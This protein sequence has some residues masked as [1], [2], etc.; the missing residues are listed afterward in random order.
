MKLRMYTIY[1]TQSIFLKATDNFQIQ[2]F[3]VAIP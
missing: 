2:S 1:G 3:F